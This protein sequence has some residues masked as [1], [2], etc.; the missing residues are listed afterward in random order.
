MF[1]TSD[2]KLLFTHPQVITSDKYNF[3]DVMKLCEQLVGETIGDF[4]F[5]EV[6]KLTLQELQT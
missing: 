3:M 6:T 4:L 5:T 1:A 2:I